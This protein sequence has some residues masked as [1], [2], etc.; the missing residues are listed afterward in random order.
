MAK[1]PLE[2]L[3]N[4]KHWKDRAEEARSNAEQLSDPEAKRMMYGIANSYEAIAARAEERSLMTTGPDSANAPQSTS[5]P[6]P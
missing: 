4:V 6:P 1:M 2:L 5:F 3:N